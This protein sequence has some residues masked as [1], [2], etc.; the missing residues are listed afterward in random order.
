M[1]SGE[2]ADRSRML[3]ADD[4]LDAFARVDLEGRIVAVN[5]PFCALVGYSFEELRGL[6]FRTLTPPEWRAAEEERVHEALA[7]GTSAPYEKEYLHRDGRRVPVALRIALHRDA[8]GHPVTMSSV[9][10]DLTEARRTEQELLGFRFAVERAGDAVY[11]LGEDGV[12][13][14]ANPAAHALLGHPAGGLVG[15]GA[16]EF[17]AQQPPAAVWARQWDQLVGPQ[18]RARAELMLLARDGFQVPVE[19]SVSTMEVGG[20]SLRVVI[21][22][23]L[24][25]RLETDL[26]LSLTRFTVEGAPFAV[27]RIDEA[28][29]IV[30]VNRQA[31]LSLGYSREELCAMTVFDIDPTFERARWIEHRSR[32]REHRS[33]TVTTRH[34]RR[35]GTTFPVEVTVRYVRYEGAEYSFSFVRDLTAQHAAEEEQ[36]RLEAQLHQAQKMESVGRLAGGVAHDFNNML[37]VILG[38]AELAA[39]ALPDTDASRPHLAAIRTAAEHARDVTRQLLGFSR[40]QIITP[41]RLD[42]NA[43]VG[44]LMRALGR[45]IGEDVEVHLHVA[46]DAWPVRFDPSQVHQVLAN[47]VVN[48]RDAMPDGGVLTIETANAHLDEA[49]CREHVEAAPGDYVVLAV[50]DTGVGMDAATRAHLFEPFFTTKAVGQGTGLGLA[51]VYGIMRQNGGVVNV[52]SEPGRGSTFRMYLPRDARAE[53]EAEPPPPPAPL[54]GS[55]TLLLVEDDALV[56]RLTAAMLESLGYDVVV[57]HSAA[58]ALER[59]ADPRQALDLLVTDVVMPMMNGRELR[60]RAQ[61]ARPGLPVLFVSGYT[62]NVVVHQGVLEAG[63]HFLQKPFSRDDLA[64]AVLAAL[65]RG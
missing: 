8:A 54:P 27:F 43:V 62:S 45:L 31:C 1:E 55:G 34:R 33:G 35:D 6:D 14:Y 20:R 12:V 18:G 59:C 49:Y 61:Q 63:A 41:R 3:S 4:L 19:M 46:P 10:R 15:R 51:T 57:A 13:T 56:R 28:G 50:S 5:A 36:R 40:K 30:D 2:H 53:G 37:S 44:E 65:G 60:A 26:A 9:V 23:D 52:Y 42:L 17:D 47:L 16:W 29:D 11:W 32:I 22:R 25:E 48:A 58:H 21:A 7:R 64:R 24:R 39:R 38:H